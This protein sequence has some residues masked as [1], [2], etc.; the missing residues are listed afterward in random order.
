MKVTY[1][2]LDVVKDGSKWPQE[3]SHTIRTKRVEYEKGN[4]ADFV[5]A[6]EEIGKDYKC[7]DEKNGIFLKE[8][9]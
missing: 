5:A 4:I 3:I 6:K 9:K 1:K 7:W 8:V 2:N